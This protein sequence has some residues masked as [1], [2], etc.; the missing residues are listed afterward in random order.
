MLLAGFDFSENGFARDE[1]DAPI[2]L[3]DL[4]LDH[5]QQTSRQFF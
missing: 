2:F 3:A 5:D 4:H 1:M